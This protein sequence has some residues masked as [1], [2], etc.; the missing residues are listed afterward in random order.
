M[1]SLED[2]FAFARS[3]GKQRGDIAVALLTRLRDRLVG[4]TGFVSYEVRGCRDRRERFTLEL[5]IHGN[6]QLQC[7]WCMAP[8]NYPL[9][10]HA[11]VLLAGP[12]KVPHED[13]DLSDP[14]WIEAGHDLNLVELMEDEILLGLPVSVRHAR[15][16]CQADGLV[17]SGTH[18]AESPFAGLAGLQDVGR[19]HTR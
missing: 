14:E 6:L 8:V 16:D 1:H 9:K 12:G 19:T 5:E 17:Q 11:T 10:I 7:G 18:A 3:A 15:T 4:D 2:P 13:D